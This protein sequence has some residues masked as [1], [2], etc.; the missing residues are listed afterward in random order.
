MMK[1]IATAMGLGQRNTDEPNDNALP[2]PGADPTIQR[3]LGERGGED[4]DDESWALVMA[5]IRGATRAIS[6]TQEGE[7]QMPD[8]C[9]NLPT[10]QIAAQPTIIQEAF[11]GITNAIQE[12]GTP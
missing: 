2:A 11:S 1:G 10:V 4:N 9:Q 3:M 7:Q 12:T 5:G 6:Q 8:Q